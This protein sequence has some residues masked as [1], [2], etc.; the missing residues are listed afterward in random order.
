MST[1]PNNLSA[2][3]VGQYAAILFQQAHQSKRYDVLGFLNDELDSSNV[4][5]IESRLRDMGMSVNDTYGVY[6]ASTHQLAIDSG[7]MEPYET[8]ALRV[9]RE[10]R[11]ILQVGQGRGKGLI[12]LSPA[13]DPY[14]N[15]GNSIPAAPADLT[16][17]IPDIAELQQQLNEKEEELRTTNSQLETTNSQLRR[18]ETEI[19]LLQEKLR[20]QSLATWR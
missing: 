10:E 6:P 9:L 17:S 7:I 4:E 13:V 20:I 15:E 16:S 8:A 12:L 14:G 3:R 2:E 18:R 1:Q 5:T 11:K 19:R